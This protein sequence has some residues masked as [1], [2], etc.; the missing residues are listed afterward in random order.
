MLGCRHVQRLGAINGPN[1][2]PAAGASAAA[3]LHAARAATPSAI[4]CTERRP[5]RRQPTSTPRLLLTPN[6]CTAPPHAIARARHVRSARAR[7]AS[8]SRHRATQTA[9]TARSHARA[10]T[11]R[12]IAHR[13]LSVSP[14]SA[15]SCAEIARVQG[16]A[17]RPLAARTAHAG[18]RR[19]AAAGRA[20]GRTAA[21]AAIVAAGC[22]PC[23]ASADGRVRRAGKRVLGRCKPHARAAPPACACGYEGRDCGRPCGIGVGTAGWVQPGCLMLGSPGSTRAHRPRSLPSVKSVDWV[24]LNGILQRTTNVARLVIVVAQY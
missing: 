24:V 12:R 2:L 3:L 1:K 22:A 13:G 18:T 16:R 15:K 8:G 7:Q 23:G 20:R 14:R 10:R 6:D 17:P 9:Q 4:P 5:L 19:T 21:R 11:P